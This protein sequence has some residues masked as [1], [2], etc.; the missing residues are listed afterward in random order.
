MDARRAHGPCRCRHICRA[1]DSASAQ[2]QD[3]EESSWIRKNASSGWKS[4]PIFQ[5]ERLRELNEALTAQQQ[6]IDTLEHRLAETMEL[7]RNLRDQLG[8]TGNG[9]L[10]ITIAAP[11]TC[12]RAL[13]IGPGDRQVSRGE[14]GEGNRFVKTVLPLPSHSPA[15][16]PKPFIG[17]MA[18]DFLG[19]PPAPRPPAAWK[20]RVCDMT[21]RERMKFPAVSG[22]DPKSCAMPGFFLCKKT[23]QKKPCASSDGAAKGLQLCAFAPKTG[24]GPTVS[25]N[26]GSGRTRTSPSGRVPSPTPPVTG[27]R[28]PTPTRPSDGI[29]STNVPSVPVATVS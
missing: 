11:T 17:S 2:A 27:T 26:P 12:P 9:A 25:A 20:G 19:L 18:G 4:W 8:Q 6:Q 29:A 21:M 15:P 14:G 24:R 3:A 22:Y 13:L 5:E 7:A 16:F 10:K 1:G 28:P 23:C